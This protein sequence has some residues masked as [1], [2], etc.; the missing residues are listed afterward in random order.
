M[1]CDGRGCSVLAHLHCYFTA[2]SRDTNDAITDIEHW[3]CENCGVPGT[4]RP[5]S[6]YLA[7]SG[8]TCARGGGGGGGGGGGAEVVWTDLLF[9]WKKKRMRGR[10]EEGYR[11]RVGE[12]LEKA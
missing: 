5:G 1:I 2:G 10:A 8:R 11:P 12:C 3:H 4:A 9:E 6:P 7:H